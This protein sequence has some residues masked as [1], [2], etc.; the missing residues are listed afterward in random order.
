M[1]T[2]LFIGAI[3]LSGILVTA[4]DVLL[5]CPEKK[6]KTICHI[7]FRDT[8]FVN[9]LTFAVSRYA[10]GAE[11]IFFPNQHL[12]I[13]GLKLL[14][15]SLVLGL[16]YLCFEGLVSGF[17]AFEKDET[18]EHK[19]RAW[20]ARIISAVLFTLGVAAITGTNFAKTAFNDISPDEMLVTL[21]SPITGTGSDVMNLALEGPFLLT[22]LFATIF[23]MIVFPKWKFVYRGKEKTKTIL[24]AFARRI[25][26]LVLSVLILAG[27]LAFGIKELQL[28]KLYAA[29]VD[30]DPFIEEHY[31][32][33]AEVKMQFPEKKRNL[34]H[35]YLE[36]VENS[37]LSRELGGYM[38]DN[39]MP[40]LTDLAREGFNFSHLSDRKQLG[41]PTTT[42]GATWSVAS[43]VNQCFGFPMKVPVDGNA[44]G[45]PDHFIPGAFGLG[46]I[47]HQQGYVQEVMFGADADFGGLTYMYESHGDFTIFDYKSAKKDGWI[48]KD[49]LEW[50]GFEDDKLYEFAKKEITRLYETGK[51]FNFT[52]ENADTHFPDGYLSPGVGN[53]Y[54]SQY[55][56]VIAYS[57]SQ[58]TEFVRWIQAQPFYENTTVILIGDHLSMDQKFF[59]DF[60]SNYKRTTYNLIL[61]PAPSVANTAEETTLNRMWATFDMFPTILASLGVQIEG[62]RLGLG[63][64]LF[65]GAPTIYEQYPN[66]DLWD[67]FYKRS[68]FYNQQFLL[69]Q[70]GEFTGDNITTY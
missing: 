70:R 12:A 23:C 39:L 58:V 10:L 38:Q 64:N 54:D 31:K 33:P 16:I 30:E 49:Y 37:Y 48:P 53:K 26:A 66:D 24:S 21:M 6:A 32:N 29:Y 65:S 3:L 28:N 47:L 25:V 11:K 18:K 5:F 35:I 20:T 17:F 7:F 14:A 2:A 57:S 46:D 60:D 15:V 22:A 34:I 40:E 36:S 42:Y 44:Y 56:N 55:A 50:W 4:A 1:Y 8:I 43:M 63:T 62:E 19:G 68:N 69:S 67:T 13:Y 45:T 61:N 9:L 27:G 52:M 59:K 41:G 51:P